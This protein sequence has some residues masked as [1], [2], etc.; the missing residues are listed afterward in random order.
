MLLTRSQIRLIRASTGVV[1]GAV[2][3]LAT[4]GTY[5]GW[6]FRS[7]TKGTDPAVIVLIGL[8][9]VTFLAQKAGAFPE[10]AAWKTLLKAIGYCALAFLWIGLVTRQVPDTASGVTLLMGP[11]YVLLLAG[12]FYFTRFA[13]KRGTWWSSALTRSLQTSRPLPPSI[14]G[15]APMVNLSASGRDLSGYVE[16]AANRMA[17][18]LRLLAFVAFAAV[19]GPTLYLFEKGTLSPIAFGVAFGTPAAFVLLWFLWA[20]TAIG[21][22]MTL[23]STGLS[24][25]RGLCATRRLTWPEISG[26]ELRTSGLY[27]FLVVHVREAESL[28]AAQGV[29]GRWLMR[30]SQK[31]FGSPVRIPTS[32][33]KCDRDWLLQTANDML[34][35]HGQQLKSATGTGG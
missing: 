32:W 6:L 7:H 33:L 14:P 24:M 4:I 15:S 8:L 5:D 29:V 12:M 34:A 11:T 25:Q 16:I 22:A 18:L 35:A 20:L 19:M 26:F 17:G 9:A 23:G 30:Q 1:Y 13:A 31:T 21:P 10:V 3:A 2:A 28:I 27:A